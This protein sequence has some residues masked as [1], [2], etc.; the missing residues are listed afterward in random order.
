MRGPELGRWSPT[1]V[2]AVASHATPMKKLPSPTA[3]LGVGWMV[4]VVPF[5]RS[6]RVVV[7]EL[8]VPFRFP[9]AVQAAGAVQDTAAR[10]PPGGGLGVRWMAHFRP[11]HRSASVPAGL[12]ALSGRAPT[13]GQKE[14]EVEDPPAKKTPGAHEGAGT[15][16]ICHCWPFH[17]S[18][19]SPV[20]KPELS[21]DVPTAM[22]NMRAVQ[23]TPNRATPGTPAGM[24]VGWTVQ[25][26]P[27]H[28]SAS[29]CVGRPPR[30][31]VLAPPAA[32]PA[33]HS[34]DTAAG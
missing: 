16:W 27:F 19:K 8:E 18:A 9:A 14:G 29:G 31:W 15:G 24:G 10:T 22:Q 1:A 5:H 2:Q 17:R 6:A 3:S 20:G 26:V 28:R 7:P 23:A 34:H 11:F 33:G 4:Q 30:M 32:A 21:K 12:P 25:F 13:A